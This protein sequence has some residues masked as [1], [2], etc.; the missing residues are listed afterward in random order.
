MGAVPA[1]TLQSIKC[2]ESMPM[3]KGDLKTLLKPTWYRPRKLMKTDR[4]RY[5]CDNVWLRTLFY[6]KG[7]LPEMV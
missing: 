1:D 3:G 7:R 4:N 5:D 2:V 6:G